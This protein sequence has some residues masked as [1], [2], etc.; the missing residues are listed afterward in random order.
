[1]DFDNSEMPLENGDK[2]YIWYNTWV[3]FMGL[4]MKKIHMMKD[5]TILSF[6]AMRERTRR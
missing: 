1:M 5:V 6:P 4:F 2:D 3:D